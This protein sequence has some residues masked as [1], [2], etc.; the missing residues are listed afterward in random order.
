[1][2]ALRV[3]DALALISHWTSDGRPMPGKFPHVQ[4]HSGEVE[5]WDPVRNLPRNF[6]QED[7][8]ETL[9]KYELREL[10]MGKEI[11]LVFPAR[12]LRCVTISLSRPIIKFYS[13]SLA[14]RYKNASDPQRPPL[15]IRSVQPSASEPHGMRTSR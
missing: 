1:M 7:W 2:D 8:L 11:N 12:L 10:N 13:P 4:T 9:D 15:P 5:N 6:Y 3:L 14:A